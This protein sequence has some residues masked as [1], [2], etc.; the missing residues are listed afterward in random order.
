[1]YYKSE[2]DQ[3]KNKD[4]QTLVRGTEGKYVNSCCFPGKVQSDINC[5][6]FFEQLGTKVRIFDN[7]NYE[8]V[9]LDLGTAHNYLW[10]VFPK[11]SG[12]TGEK[13]ADTNY[14]SWQNKAES[15]IVP[16]NVKAELYDGG[17]SIIDQ[18]SNSKN[19]KLYDGKT[20]GQLVPKL[21]FKPD[22][23]VIS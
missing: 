16:P 2:A 3:K 4:P 19:Y 1:V 15:M 22:Q 9:H 23:I 21:D 14:K 18:K 12:D 20:A 8:G 17:G 13:I 5:P 10:D 7:K 11:Y 6:T